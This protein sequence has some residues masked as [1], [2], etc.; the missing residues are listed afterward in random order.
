MQGSQPA[1]ALSE[2]DY[3]QRSLARAAEYKRMMKLQTGGAGVRPI[4]SS[5]GGAEQRYCIIHD[6]RSH[7]T[8]QCDLVKDIYKQ[9]P[10]EPATQARTKQ[11]TFVPSNQGN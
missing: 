9:P 4:D 6:S 10:E 5:E 3:K 7:T 8:G 11:V 1:R 2:Y